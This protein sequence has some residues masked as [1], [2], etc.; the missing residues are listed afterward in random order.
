MPEK[1]N[2]WHGLLRLLERIHLGVWIGGLLLSVA[3][4]VWEIVRGNVFLATLVVVLVI[5]CTAVIVSLLT[6][7]RK[8]AKRTKAAIK[9]ARRIVQEGYW[10]YGPPTGEGVGHTHFDFASTFRGF[11]RAVSEYQAKDR[12]RLRAHSERIA[13]VT[14]FHEKSTWEELKPLLDKL[15]RWVEWAERAH[16]KVER[17]PLD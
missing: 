11:D 13:Q 15:E 12:D 17:H 5:L 10:V 3:L 4:A 1:T 16:P 8:V 9:Q 14:R 6:H 2:P 7:V